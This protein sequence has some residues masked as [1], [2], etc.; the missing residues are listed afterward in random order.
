MPQDEMRRN[1]LRVLCNYE[2]TLQNEE[3]LC[4]ELFFL[5]SSLHYYDNMFISA[6]VAGAVFST[7]KP[8]AALRQ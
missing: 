3:S 7:G 2:P 8:S 4:G 6:L 1:E 5:P